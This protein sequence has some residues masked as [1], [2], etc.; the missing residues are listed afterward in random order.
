MNGRAAIL[1]FEDVSKRYGSRAVVDHFTL[2]VAGGSIAALSGVNGSGKSTLFR[3]A[4]GFVRPFEGTISL[5]APGAEPTLLLDLSPSQRA[6]SGLSYI[7]QDRLI[8]SRLSTLE[9]LRIA[10]APQRLTSTAIAESLRTLRLTRLIEQ[11]PSTMSPTDVM[12]L[13]LARAYLM[14]PRFLLADEPFARLDR[15]G[16]IHGMAILRKLRE[17]GTGILLTDHSP[18]PLLAIADT[19]HIMQGGRLVYSDSAATT[20]TSAEARRLYFRTHD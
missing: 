4:A 9:N 18:K 13:L 3:I 10:T 2:S 12:L 14:N 19:V 6:L 15:R 1:Q 8:L 5:I 17:R 16:V 11:R 7:S 20:R